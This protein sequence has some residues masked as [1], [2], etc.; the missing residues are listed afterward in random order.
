MKEIEVTTK[1][2]VKEDGEI[3]AEV[4]Q[5]A[6][7]P[8]NESNAAAGYIIHSDNDKDI[9]EG[10]AERYAITSDLANVCEYLEDSEVIKIKLIIQKA[11]ARKG[12]E[13][14]G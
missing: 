7:T 8:D 5:A 1:I 4:K 12:R 2:T 6:D 10:E 14:R 13:E 3:L 9:T 11:Q